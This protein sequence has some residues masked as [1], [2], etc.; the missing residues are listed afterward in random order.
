MTSGGCQPGR[1]WSTGADHHH[2]TTPHHT[3]PPHPTLRGVGQHEAGCLSTHGVAHKWGKSLQNLIGMIY[4]PGLEI[5]RVH[6]R[7]V[8]G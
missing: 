2:T 1:P 8:R 4:Q 7:S 6:A 5:A 3:T